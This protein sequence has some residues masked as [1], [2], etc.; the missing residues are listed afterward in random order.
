MTQMTQ[1]TQPDLRALRNLRLAVAE[2][3][4]YTRASWPARNWPWYSFA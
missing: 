1:M 4:S 2:S 3:R